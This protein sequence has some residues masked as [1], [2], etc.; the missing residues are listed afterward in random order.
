M[1]ED[2][3]QYRSGIEF[4]GLPLEYQKLINR[5]LLNRQTDARRAQIREEQSDQ[6][7]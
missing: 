1:L 5:Y 3:S 2:F 7:F 4:V 6:F